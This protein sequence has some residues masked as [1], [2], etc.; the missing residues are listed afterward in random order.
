MSLMRIE[1]SVND[2]HPKNTV[3]AMTGHPM[4]LADES[5]ALGVD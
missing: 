5:I 2:I 1:C 4:R 3:A